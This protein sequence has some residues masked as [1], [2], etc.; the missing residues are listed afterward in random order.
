MSGEP[1]PGRNQPCSRSE[2]RMSGEQLTI[3]NASPGPAARQSCVRGW[4]APVPAR[5]P[6][7]NGQEQF[8]CGTPPPAA[9]PSIRTRMPPTPTD[10]AAVSPTLVG[11]DLQARL[12]HL[13]DR[14]TPGGALLS[15]RGPVG[16]PGSKLCRASAGL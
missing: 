8:H 11:S 7:Q 4:V 1:P 5:A 16:K 2:L 13:D 12:D 9:L 14:L 10:L 15:C 3:A 6:L